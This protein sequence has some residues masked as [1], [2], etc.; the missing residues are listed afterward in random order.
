MLKEFFL[1]PLLAC[2]KQLT[3]LFLSLLIITLMQAMFLLLTGPVLTLLF[4][5]P[6][7][8]LPL[9]Q[10]SPL[11]ARLLPDLSF[12]REFFFALATCVA[13]TDGADQE[14][15]C[16]SVSL[17]PKL[18]FLV[19]S[20]AFTARVV[21]GNHCPTL[22]VFFAQTYGTLDVNYYERYVLVASAF[23]RHHDLLY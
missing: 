11:A 2:K 13:S 14:C 22:H 7:A 6:N 8:T 19:V 16:L 21:C 9:A 5:E 23:F 15:L 4:S 10:L 1:P 3:L 18:H 12:P 17:L 20:Q